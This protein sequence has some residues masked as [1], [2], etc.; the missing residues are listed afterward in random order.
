MGLNFVCEE[1]A[2]SPT[3]IAREGKERKGRRGGK[4]IGKEGR[5]GV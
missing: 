2:N 3:V 5:N 4:W 1:N